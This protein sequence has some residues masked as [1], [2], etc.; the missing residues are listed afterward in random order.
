LSKSKRVD[1]ETGYVE[2]LKSKKRNSDWDSRNKNFLQFF[3]ILASEEPSLGTFVDLCAGTGSMFSVVAPLVKLNKWV[4][5]DRDPEC[6][7]VWNDIKKDNPTDINIEVYG[8]DCLDFRTPEKI[9]SAYFDPN[10]FSIHKKYDKTWEQIGELLNNNNIEHMAFVDTACYYFRI[11]GDGS[12][13]GCM[14]FDNYIEAHQAKL[15]SLTND[16][17]ELMFYSEYSSRKCGQFFYKKIRSNQEFEKIRKYKASGHYQ[18]FV[19]ELPKK[20]DQTKGGLF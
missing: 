12:P 14:T 19:Q 5:I 7:E 17:Y 15:N 16:H 11:K 13:Y 6:I 8:I 1:N 2:L 10:T 20:I 18:K 9:T 4:A 3:S